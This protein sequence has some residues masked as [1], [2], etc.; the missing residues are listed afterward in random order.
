M[1]TVFFLF[2]FGVFA[3]VCTFALKH[4]VICVFFEIVT[5]NS[6]MLC[7]KEGVVKRCLSC[8]WSWTKCVYTHII[9]VTY[10]YISI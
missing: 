6:E 9:Y 5:D 4:A 2:F 1:R 10:L 8:I 3:H 7:N